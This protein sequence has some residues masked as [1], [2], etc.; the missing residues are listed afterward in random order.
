VFH[1]L[2]SYAVLSAAEFESCRAVACRRVAGQLSQVICCISAVSIC[3]KSY[4]V[5]LALVTDNAARGQQ[6]WE[7]G[8]ACAAGRGSVVTTFGP[9]LGCSAAHLIVLLGKCTLPG[10]RPGVRSRIL[11]LCCEHLL[12]TL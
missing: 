8:G 4:R 5:A 1:C 7:H 2:W 12:E 6:V 11:H 3:L 9:M 10:C